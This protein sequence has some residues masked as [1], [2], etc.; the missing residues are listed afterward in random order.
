[1]IALYKFITLKWKFYKYYME[2]GNIAWNKK[3]G[4][5]S[6]VNIL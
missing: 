2:R 5:K 6:Q 3:I 1:M 4:W